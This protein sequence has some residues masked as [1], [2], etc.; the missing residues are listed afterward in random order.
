M[1]NVVFFQT[2]V[3]CMTGGEKADDLRILLLCFDC[4]YP[5]MMS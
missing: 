3:E 1:K 5:M 2:A 4:C